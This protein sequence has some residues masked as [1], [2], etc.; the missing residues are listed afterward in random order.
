M[1][2]APPS[3][4]ATAHQGVGTSTGDITPGSA[5][6]VTLA[7]SGSGMFLGALRAKGWHLD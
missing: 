6:V 1:C 5:C 3:L 7:L 4:G 2:T